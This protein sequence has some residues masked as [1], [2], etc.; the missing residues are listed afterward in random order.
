[1]KNF[2]LCGLHENKKYFLLRYKYFFELSLQYR[3]LRRYDNNTYAQYFDSEILLE[4]FI[5]EYRGEVSESEEFKELE[6]NLSIYELFDEIGGRL[7]YARDKKYKYYQMCY[8]N[9][10]KTLS[11][12]K[13][14]IKDLT[15]Q[16]KL[17]NFVQLS[18]KK[19]NLS[20]RY[21]EFSRKNTKFLNLAEK[22]IKN[23]VYIRVNDIYKALR[24]S[25]ERSIDW[26]E[27]SIDWYKSSGESLERSIDWYNKGAPYVLK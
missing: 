10:F 1:M 5:D 9:I 13:K 2:D 8:K 21:Y 27:R 14:I 11:R 25:L 26:L 12:I 20:E 17:N 4:K 3:D 24:E 22:L 7:L 19:I 15:Y 6:S 18:W 16:A 23:P